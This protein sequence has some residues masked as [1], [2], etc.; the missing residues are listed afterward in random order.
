MAASW[1]F[2][3][4]EKVMGRQEIVVRLR[5][6]LAAVPDHEQARI[7]GGNTARVYKFDVTQMT[8]PV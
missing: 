1:V 4:Y 7:V 6:I 8:V 3:C 2:L 5:E